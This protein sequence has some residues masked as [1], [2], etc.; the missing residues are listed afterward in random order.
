MD[1]QNLEITEG[2]SELTFTN[3][4]VGDDEARVSRGWRTRVSRGWRTGCVWQRPR[5]SGATS[6]Q[7]SRDI[8]AVRP[9]PLRLN[10][11]NQTTTL[12]K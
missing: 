1:P 5:V 6:Q 9:L 4:N 8:G 7:S 10:S 2:K 11:I 12:S 3:L